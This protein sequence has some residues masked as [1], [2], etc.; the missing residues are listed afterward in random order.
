MT[1]DK[2]RVP[3]TNEV[4][5]TDLSRSKAQV[6]YGDCSG[7]LG[8]IDE[9]TLRIQVSIVTDDFNAVLVG[10]NRA[11]TTQAIKNRLEGIVVG[12][13]AQRVVPLQTGTTKIV[14]NT[15]SK[16]IPGDVLCQLPEHS[17]YHAGR[18]LLG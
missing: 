12:R 13:G 8:V 18:K 16:M 2:I 3:V 14:V 15:N 4:A 17:S 5:G 1:G 9:I 11:V 10:A 7:L 6:G